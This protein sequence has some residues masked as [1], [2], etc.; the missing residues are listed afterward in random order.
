MDGCERVHM[1]AVCLYGCVGA[2]GHGE[3]QKRDKHRQNRLA[4]LGFGCMYDRDIPEN[5][6]MCAQTCKRCNK[7]LRRA[8]MVEDRCRGTY[9]N[10]PNSKQTETSDFYVIIIK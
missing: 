9:Y 4:G 1:V 8:G 7:G 6:S 3:T 2:L 10:E 5:T